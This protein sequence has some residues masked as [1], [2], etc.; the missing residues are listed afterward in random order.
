MGGEVEAPGGEVE[1]HG[2]EDDAPERL[3]AGGGDVEFEDGAVGL[4]G[5]LH[6]LGDQRGEA[7][8]E[9]REDG[10]DASGGHA[11]LVFIEERIVQLALVAVAGR[12]DAVTLGLAAHEADERLEE[13]GEGGEVGLGAGGLPGLLGEAADARELGDQVGGELGGAVVVTTELADVGGRLACRVA[14]ERAIG[15]ARADELADAPRGRTLVDHAGQHRGLV[16]AVRRR[17]GGHVGL[18]VPA[19]EGL[20]GVQGRRLARELDEL[21][22]SGGGC[23]GGR[24]GGCGGRGGG[25]GRLRR[26]GDFT[27]RKGTPRGRVG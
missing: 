8:A 15:L 5:A 19:E 9:G 4:V 24:G 27:G 25:H 6:D 1:A 12:G 13:R 23:G 2:R 16:G 17:R 21:G 10:L 20:D 18:L 26:G 7:I 11:R 3:L 22:V 14:G